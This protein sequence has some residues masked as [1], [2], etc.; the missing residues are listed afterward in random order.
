MVGNAYNH[1]KINVGIME[2]HCFRVLIIESISQPRQYY[3]FSNATI[4]FFCNRKYL[5]TLI[6]N[7]I[8]YQNINPQ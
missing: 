1:L 2:S 5:K 6:L 3:Y 4:I 8:L 7:I